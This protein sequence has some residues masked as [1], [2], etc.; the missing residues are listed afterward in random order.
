MGGGDTAT[1]NSSIK[2]TGDHVA[3]V[4]LYDNG[5]LEEEFDLDGNGFERLHERL[6]RGST[7]RTT[8]FGGSRSSG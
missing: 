8:P 5:R 2:S 6:P 3:G 7:I 1:I 4:Y